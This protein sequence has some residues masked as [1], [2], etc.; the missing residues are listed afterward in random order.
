MSNINTILSINNTIMSKYNNII[1]I[2][3]RI[4]LMSISNNVL[5][6]LIQY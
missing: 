1:L 4:C 5:L 2:I 3:I 6:I